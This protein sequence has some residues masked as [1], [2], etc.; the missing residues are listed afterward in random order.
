MQLLFELRSVIR[1]EGVDMY[2]AKNVDTDK[3]LDAINEAR[4]KIQ[5]AKVDKEIAEKRAY[6]EGIEKGLDMAES[7]FKCSNYE[8]KE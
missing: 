3:A 2:L 5:R 1:L 8:K 4:K 6:L 7:I